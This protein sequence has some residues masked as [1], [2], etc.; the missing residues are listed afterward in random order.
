MDEPERI[1]EVEREPV[2]ERQTT[3]VST[4]GDRGGGGTLLAVLLLLV[5][6]VVL[7]LLFGRGLLGGAGDDLNVNVD[8][9][10][11]DL[12]LPKAD[13]PAKPSN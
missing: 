10:T 6:V 8:V 7:F 1:V 9:K 11:P 4:G 3:V 5:A 13:P 12:E 2:V